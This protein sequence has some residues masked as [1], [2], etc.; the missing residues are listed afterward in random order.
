[1]IEMLR[2]QIRLPPAAGCQPGDM[3]LGECFGG[4]RVGIEKRESTANTY[5]LGQ[6]CYTK[7]G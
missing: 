1:V 6:D 2:G 7:V 4:K 3:K 5:R